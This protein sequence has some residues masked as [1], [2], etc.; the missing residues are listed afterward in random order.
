MPQVTAGKHYN[1]KCC[2]DYGNGET[3][4]H[5]DGPG[6]MEARNPLEPTLWGVL[7]FAA[8]SDD[9]RRGVGVWVR[10]GPW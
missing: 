4:D 8:L 6:T 3:D 1:D 2:F 7:V 10:Q 5:D 9:K